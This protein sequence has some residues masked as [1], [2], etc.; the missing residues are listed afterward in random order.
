MF[1]CATDPRG[2][3]LLEVKEQ[4]TFVTMLIDSETLSAFTVGN[5]KCLLTA[6]LWFFPP[7]ECIL[8][9][10]AY[11]IFPRVLKELADFIMGPF[12]IIIH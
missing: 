8:I 6:L 2:H 4:R 11:V 7:P 5:V 1:I 3:D 12:L 9:Y 10:G